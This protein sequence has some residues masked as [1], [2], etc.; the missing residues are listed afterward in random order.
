MFG[1][2]CIHQSDN[3]TEFT[4][5]DIHELKDV[6]IPSGATMGGLWPPLVTPLAIPIVNKSR[7]DTLIFNQYS[8]TNIID[9]NKYDL[10]TV[11]VRVL[12]HKDTRS[13][14]NLCQQR[15]LF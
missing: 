13:E 2:P 5:E 15:F 12:K 11:A 9:R 14:L 10:Y 3:G 6:A 4:S 8:S 1:A 7:G